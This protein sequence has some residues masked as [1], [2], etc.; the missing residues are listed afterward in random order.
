M[1][2]HMHLLLILRIQFKSKWN[3]LSSNRAERPPE[4][5]AGAS[6]SQGV[7]T[8]PFASGRPVFRG[9][10]LTVLWALGLCMS[11][12]LHPRQFEGAYMNILCIYI[13][14]YVDIRLYVYIDTDTNTYIYIYTYIYTRLWSV[15]F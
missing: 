5:R 15:G 2:A 12:Y 14:T 13:Y 8:S 9:S 7:R 6:R 1:H 4:A 11:L 3:S 10:R